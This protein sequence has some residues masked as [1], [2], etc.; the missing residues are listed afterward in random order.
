MSEHI[1]IEAELDDDGRTIIFQTNLRLSGAEEVEHYATAAALTEGSPVAQAFASVDGIATA[2]LAGSLL[3]IT[4]DP[5]ADVHAVAA[6]VSAA[7][8]EFFL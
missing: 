3:T 8:K 5:A 4:C 2:E 7:L 6:D 1:E